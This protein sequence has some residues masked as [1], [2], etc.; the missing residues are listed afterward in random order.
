[1]AKSKGK[2]ATNATVDLGDILQGLMYMGAQSN[3]AENADDVWQDRITQR[4]LASDSQFYLSG[5]E[6]RTENINDKISDLETQHANYLE[7]HPDRYKPGTHAHDSVV[8]RLDNMKL[9]G[10]KAEEFMQKYES[11][12]TS[13]DVHFQEY[14]VPV[15]DE[16]GEQMFYRNP[17]GGVRIDENG[18]PMPI[19]RSTTKWD[20]LRYELAN[21][22]DIDYMTGERTVSSR[23]LEIQDEMLRYQD[24]IGRNLADFLSTH[25]EF[26]NIQNDEFIGNMR[27]TVTAFKNIY[28]EERRN[29][30]AIDDTWGGD[31]IQDQGYWEGLKLAADT[32]QWEDFD[33]MQKENRA[34]RNETLRGLRAEAESFRKP[35]MQKYVYLHPED[36]MTPGQPLEDGTPTYKHTYTDSSGETIVNDVT[37]QWLIGQYYPSY[38]EDVSKISM[39]ENQIWNMDGPQ[40]TSVLIKG[41]RRYIRPMSLQKFMK[42]PHPNQ[43]NLEPN[44]GE[45][46]LNAVDATSNNPLKVDKELGPQKIDL[47]VLKN[48]PQNKI[49]NAHKNFV[50]F[51]E[52]EHGDKIRVLENIALT[53]KVSE[54]TKDE[55]DKHVQFFNQADI[56]KQGALLKYNL[57]KQKYVP[58]SIRNKVNKFVKESKKGAFIVPQ[59][60]EEYYN[61]MYPPQKKHGEILN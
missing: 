31:F 34:E 25:R 3:R 21:N 55:V 43:P 47:G 12:I 44:H 29:L 15:Y 30:Q 46:N 57:P 26:I 50:S 53:K 20:E 24:N 16:D 52:L 1:M 37:K 14:S 39:I 48:V 6:Y 61:I 36:L 18:L 54:M 40:R 32:D 5:N 60:L 41:D 38:K 51:A 45:I 56:Y 8:E 9:Q 11:L 49:K 10:M 17:D 13:N 35:Y 27:N 23:A 7:N 22:S 28:E 42:E 59:E 58:L 2:W 33:I 4:L 19:L